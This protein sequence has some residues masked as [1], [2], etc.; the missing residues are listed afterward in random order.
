MKTKIL[1]LALLSG[2]VF[3]V[4]AQ[5]FQ[6]Q[7]GFSTEKG[8]KT[9]FK[10]NKAG[11]NWFISIAGGA[12][13]LL[14]DQNNKADFGNR[15]NFAPQFSF[16]K[17]FNP[18]LAFRT[19]LNGGILHGFVG[20]D[21]QLMQHNKYMAAHVDLLWDVTNFW[22]PYRE[23]KVFRLIPW[24]GL[25]YA[26][27]FKTTEAAEFARSESPSLNAGILMA[28]RVSKRVDINVE[29]QGSLLN[30]QFNRVSMGH[31][32]DGI[33]QLSAGLTFK[34]GKTDFEV[35]QPMD[36]A[37]LNDLNNQIN[38]LRAAN[39]ELSKRP[40]SCPECEEVVTEVVNN[41][42]DNV[43]YFRL[44]SSKIDKNQQISIYNTAEFMKNNNTPIKVVGY[45]DKKTGTS[46]Y[47]MGLSEK[48]AKA[49]AKELIEKYGI[50][51]D[52]ITIEWKGSDVQPYG[53]N[54]WNRVVIMSAN[55]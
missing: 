38:S 13:I 40:V 47:N 32:S 50:S 28:F 10:K 42:V 33:A 37:L 20:D 44:N 12:S 52:Q 48:R 24:V 39:D 14:G 25:G 21:A 7:I 30:E 49:V 43:V 1:L 8:Y 36:Y 4:S 45:A 17:W 22:A 35:L 23:S 51:S 5:E 54:N 27:R 41:Y 3:S 26:Q 11:D 31:L 16:G 15:L 53:E 46:N 9:N 55:N 2:F 18:Y 34:L 29:A 19:Q 6:P